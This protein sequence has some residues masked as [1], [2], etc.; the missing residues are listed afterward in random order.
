MKFIQ[1]ILPE[2]YDI[3]KNGISLDLI[4]AEI[5]DDLQSGSI[6]MKIAAADFFNSLFLLEDPEFLFLSNDFNFDEFCINFL[7]SDDHLL[8]MCFF[9]VI[10]TITKIE[11]PKNGVE[12]PFLQKIWKAPI[13]SFL[14]DSDN[15][16]NDENDKEYNQMKQEFFLSVTQIRE[17][18]LNE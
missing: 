1:S 16:D 7:D 17:L 4:W 10:N 13:D 15:N 14:G 11:V 12:S 5:E 8:Q 6:K 3:I 9:K 18:F 2:K